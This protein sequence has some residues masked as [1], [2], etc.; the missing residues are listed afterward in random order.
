MNIYFLVITKTS[1]F[2]MEVSRSWLENDFA[3][4]RH[5]EHST[6]TSCLLDIRNV[7]EEHIQKVFV[8]SKYNISSIYHVNFENLV[9]FTR[10]FQEYLELTFDI[11]MIYVMKT[12]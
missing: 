12:H 9:I 1:S 7:D 5:I 2:V 8:E 10:A 6:G 11:L 3:E 4:S